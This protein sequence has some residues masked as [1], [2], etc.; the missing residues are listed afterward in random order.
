MILIVILK[1]S[2]EVTRILVPNPLPQKVSKHKRESKLSPHSPHIW[3]TRNAFP[4]F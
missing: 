2:H 4:Q 3:K 1:E